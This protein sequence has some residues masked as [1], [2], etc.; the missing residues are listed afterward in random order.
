[1]LLLKFKLGPRLFEFIERKAQ[2]LKQRTKAAKCLLLLF[3]FIYLWQRLS[4][5]WMISKAQK[6]FRFESPAG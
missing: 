1:M 4:G 2:L 6:G 5:Y 3:L